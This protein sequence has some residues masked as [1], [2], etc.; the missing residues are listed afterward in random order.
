MGAWLYDDPSFALRSVTVRRSPSGAPPSDS[1]DLVFVGCNR[2]DYDLLGEGFTTRLAVD[3]HTIGQGARE[4][5]V[6]L[7]TRDTSSF[8]VTVPL[9]S[10]TLAGG[11]TRA[12]FELSSRS[13]VRTPMGD[14]P[15]AFRLHGRVDL[16]DSSSLWMTEGAPICRPGVSQLPG[17]FDRRV[18]LSTPREEP[19]RAPPMP[20]P[21]EGGA[22]P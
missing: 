6:L 2:N 15:V 22:T 7:A 1:L 21:G 9:Q 14:R 4:Q 8:V 3:G 20:A 5:P 13:M 12:P 11:T 18:P 17:V 19:P 10:Q 16:N